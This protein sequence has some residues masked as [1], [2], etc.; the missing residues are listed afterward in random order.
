MD[1][2][3]YW[4]VI[5]ANPVPFILFAVVIGGFMWLVAS[6]YYAG[7]VSTAKAQAELAEKQR[8]EFKS[9]LSALTP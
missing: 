1:L 3:K 4:P 5:S 9:K 2:E 6:L 8:D 7:Q